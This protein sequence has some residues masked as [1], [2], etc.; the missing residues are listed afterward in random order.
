M[1]WTKEF[2]DFALKGNMIDMAV[3]VI[4]GAA[5][6]KVVDSLVKDI[7]MPPI[8][9]L[10]GGVDFRQL[11]VSLNGVAYENLAAAEKAGAPL[12]KYGAFISALTDFTI[13]ALAIFFAIGIVNRLRA[14]QPPTV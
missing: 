13:I 8:G 3:G 11:Y 1:G 12:L 6:A 2:R 9:M 4:I 7:V 14:R 5:F 10:L